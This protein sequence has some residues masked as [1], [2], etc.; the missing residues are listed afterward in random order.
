MKDIYGM[1]LDYQLRLQS[2]RFCLVQDQVQIRLPVNAATDMKAYI[3]PDRVPI[4]RISE[5]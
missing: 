1:L 3:V 2:R 5:I 4:S